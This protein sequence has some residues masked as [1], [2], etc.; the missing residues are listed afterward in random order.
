MLTYFSCS[1]HIE[2]EL[3]LLLSTFFFDTYYCQ[4]IDANNVKIHFNEL[5][6]LIGWH[7]LIFPIELS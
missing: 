6:S 3:I 4:L 7:R 1:M 2:E 5:H